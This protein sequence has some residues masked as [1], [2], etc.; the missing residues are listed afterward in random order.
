MV[1]DEIRFVS[2]P[3]YQSQISV[4]VEVASALHLTADVATPAASPSS[5]TA[6]ATKPAPIT[7]WSLSYLPPLNLC[8]VLPPSYPSKSPPRF[9]LSCLWLNVRQLSLLCRELDSL[10]RTS[11]EQVVI[12]SWVEFL[13]RN[14]LPFLSIESTLSLHPPPPHTPPPNEP[15]GPD[16]RAISGLGS[17]EADL[18]ALVRF[19]E[20]R[21]QSV[22]L[23]EI[24]TCSICL[25]DHPGLILI[26]VWQMI[27]SCT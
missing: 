11:S 7:S 20:G 27:H 2:S 4:H 24:H 12:F 1:S 10:A 17:V 6:P 15:A 8:C 21:K 22:F 9:T 5:E 3:P 16:P 13:A 26:S 23:Q 25:S 18:R 14:S 19:N